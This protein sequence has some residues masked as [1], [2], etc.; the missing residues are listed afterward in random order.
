MEK[1][2]VLPLEGL[3]DELDHL[4]ELHHGRP[5]VW[6]QGC[7]AACEGH[8]AAQA[9]VRLLEQLGHIGRHKVKAG[10]QQPLQYTS[11]DLIVLLAPQGEGADAVDPVLK[12]LHLRAGRAL[13]L[14]PL[15][16]S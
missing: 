16:L 15:R 2:H 9:V 5:V 4:L 3:V 13:A 7:V 14:G 11:H 6:C 10:T 12:L 8:T 1:G